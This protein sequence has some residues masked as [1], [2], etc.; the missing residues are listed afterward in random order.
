MQ[1]ESVCGFTMTI[2]DESPEARAA[3]HK[4]KTIIEDCCGLVKKKMLE[5][6]CAFS[7][8]TKLHIRNHLFAV[9][10][11]DRRALL[12]CFYHA[13]S[14]RFYFSASPEAILGIDA[15]KLQ[16]LA[17]RECTYLDH[18]ADGKK[19]PTQRALEEKILQM[20]ARNPVIFQPIE[21]QAILSICEHILDEEELDYS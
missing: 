21:Q 13:D 12:F 1:S 19:I 6:S 3:F 4:A 11:A 2:K 18:L 20:K 16:A 10:Y 14:D 15:K 9:M 5:T 8:V 7:A 17:Y